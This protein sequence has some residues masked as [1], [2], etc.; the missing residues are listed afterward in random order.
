MEGSQATPIV[1]V[2]ENAYQPRSQS[3][4]QGSLSKEVSRW[5]ALWLVHFLKF[6]FFRKIFSPYVRYWQQKGTQPCR[7]VVQ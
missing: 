5:L 2:K 4:N 6:F 1:I 3:Y 7:A